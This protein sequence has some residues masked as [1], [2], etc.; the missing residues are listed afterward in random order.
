MQHP[1]SPSEKPATW[2]VRLASTPWSSS[3]TM[4]TIEPTSHNQKMGRMY[5]ASLSKQMTNDSR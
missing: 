2:Y 1:N 5:H 3:A 4:L